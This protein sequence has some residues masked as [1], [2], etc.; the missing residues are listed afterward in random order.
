[1]LNQTGLLR[2]AC[3]SG[4]EPVAMPEVYLRKVVPA[5]RRD[6]KSFQ[7]DFGTWQTTI[8]RLVRFW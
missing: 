1:M 6:G 7:Q 3:A 2:D 5:C 4:V 8:T